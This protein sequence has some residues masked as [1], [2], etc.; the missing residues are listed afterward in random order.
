MN[1]ALTTLTSGNPT[2]F[3]TCRR[4]KM[5]PTNPVAPITV[6]LITTEQLGRASD[7]FIA[8][9]RKNAASLPKDLSQ[10]VLE[11]EGDELAQEMFEALRKRVERRS[12]TI[13]RRTI[14]NRDQM[15][16]QMVNATGRKQYVSAETIKTI[17]RQGTGTEEVEL[18]FFNPGRGLTIDEQ[19]QELAAYGLVPD[20]YAQVQVNIDDP[21]FADEHPNGAQWD[22]KDGQA[23]FLTFSRWSGE[24][25]VDCDRSDDDWHGNWWFAGVRKS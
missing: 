20:Y 21:S 14:V 3:T 15:P 25:R 2:D 12:K 19:E 13:V 23:S 5:T 22:N 24:R 7:R 9:C 6:D 16:E 17:P 1:L 4:N 11:N 10:Q 8:R 18:Y